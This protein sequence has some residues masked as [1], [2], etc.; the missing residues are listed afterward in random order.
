[1]GRDAEQAST[2]AE[3]DERS[4]FRALVQRTHVVAFR[5]ALRM[6]GD[7]TEAEDALQEAYLRAW[8]GRATLRDPVA[9]PAWIF[10]IVR[11]VASNRAR[12]RSR[13]K[14]HEV[15][16]DADTLHRLAEYLACERPGPEQEA[17][18]SQM[19]A[20]VMRLV[21]QLDERYRVILM[22]RVVDGMSY[23][24]LAETLGVPA[25]TVESRLHRARQQ[26]DKK[27]ERALGRGSRGAP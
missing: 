13:R 2:P 18:G 26:L 8:N 12:G 10:G 17:A 19:Q 20:V 11:N 14:G 15:I 21:Q 9:A 25:G 16:A 23:D 6:L 5:V 1:V 7:A 4:A 24:E 22:L 27:L 3:A